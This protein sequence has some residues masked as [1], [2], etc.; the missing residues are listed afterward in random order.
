MKSLAQIGG[1][2]LILSTTMALGLGLS[3][4]SAQAAYVVTLTQDGSDIVAIGGGTIDTTDLVFGFSGLAVARVTPQDAAINTGPLFP[5]V[6]FLQSYLSRRNCRTKQFRA[7]E[8]N[9][10]E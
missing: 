7:R 8:R 9:L 2:L 4:P 6:D 10:R 5:T 1:G 3:A